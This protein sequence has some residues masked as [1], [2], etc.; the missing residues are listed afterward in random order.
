MSIRYP[1]GRVTLSIDPLAVPDAATSVTATASSSSAASVA[2]TAP[3]NTGV[4]AI[5]SYSVVP[6]VGGTAATGASSP[7]SVTGLT[8]DTTYTFQVTAINSAGPSPIATSNSV[9]TLASYWGLAAT[10]PTD[11]NF[12]RTVV[13]SSG[14]IY[15]SSQ[16]AST[17]AGLI[18]LNAAGVVQWQRNFSVGG[19]IDGN[20]V[21]WPGLALDSSDNVYMC[22]PVDASGPKALGI[23]V[24]YNSSGTLQWQRAL[25]DTVNS[26][27]GY[28]YSITIDSSNNIYV[29]GYTQ[30]SSRTGAYL[31][32]YNTSGVIQSQRVFY[33]PGSATPSLNGFRSVSLDSSGNIYGAS[34]GSSAS[35]G[36]DNYVFKF[37][38]AGSL[39]WQRGFGQSGLNRTDV[40]YSTVV[41]TSGNLYVGAEY[42]SSPYY[43]VLVKYN[44]SGVFQ[45][46][47]GVANG[48]RFY[49]LALDSSGNVYGV[50]IGQSP[51][52][53]ACWL[54][55]KFNSAGTVQWQRRLYAAGASWVFGITV[56]GTTMY[57]SGYIRNSSNTANIGLLMKLPTDGTLT[58]TYTIGGVSCTYDNPSYATSSGMLSGFTPTAFTVATGSIPESAGTGTDAAGANTVSK[59]S[60]P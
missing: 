51:A 32:Q 42:I 37:T 49:G 58:G 52:S 24:K 57:V 4:G 38:S 45:W 33:N 59:T 8:G 11:N 20:T 53:Q 46:S 35:Q 19:S 10:S 47:S 3:A 55:V 22:M 48:N 26:N 23:L 18:K 31:A 28:A 30:V 56:T 60:I 54:I 15:L 27:Y 21:T 1:A 25:N 13:D 7:I 40:C 2:F 34:Y 44:T 29:G 16:L 9:T 12:A 17:I 43:A 41:D 36:L 14:N 5:T 39:T 50:G 6:T